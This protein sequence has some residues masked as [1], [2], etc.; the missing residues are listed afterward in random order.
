MAHYTSHQHYDRMFGHYFYKSAIDLANDAKQRVYAPPGVIPNL[1]EAKRLYEC[2]ITD[3]NVAITDMLADPE[4][5]REC[6][7]VLTSINDKISNWR[8][9]V[10]VLTIGRKAGKTS[11]RSRR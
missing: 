11:E 5:A 10:G 2:A 6:S 8:Y 3:A 7:E 9:E 4:W 1:P